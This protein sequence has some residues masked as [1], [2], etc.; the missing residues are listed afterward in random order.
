MKTDLKAID[1]CIHTVGKNLVSLDCPLSL[2]T[3]KQLYAG[4]F[5]TL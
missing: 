3:F 1:E 5:I 4:W 2:I